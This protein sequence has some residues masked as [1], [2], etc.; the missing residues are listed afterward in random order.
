ML[1]C[2]RLSDYRILHVDGHRLWAGQGYRLFFSDDNGS[3]FT[4]RAVY[5]APF[6]LKQL[7]RVP[8][9]ERLLRGGF[10]SLLPLGDG[11][12]L[13][14]I[15]GRIIHCKS[16]SQRFV[17]VLSVPGRTLKLCATPGGVIYAGEYFL[18]PRRDEVRVFRSLDRGLNW[19]VVHTFPPGAIRHVH[20][21]VYDAYRGWV[22]LLT[23][24]LD[25]EAKVLRT[26]DGFRSLDALVEGG[27][28]S[29]AVNT[30]PV[31]EGYY[32]PTDTQFEQNYVQF[33][34]LDGELT[35][36][37]PLAGSCL[38]ACSVGGWSFFGT[39]VEPSSVNLDPSVLLYGTR[40]GREWHV[41]SRW[42]VDRWSGLTRYSAAL[43]QMARI[44][45]P[46]GDNQTGFLFAT[47]VATRGS[48]GTLHRWRVV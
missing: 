8:A 36:L 47:P 44:L 26:A 28:R 5:S 17:E 18:N 14:G 7:T 41:I 43:F 39:A 3:S 1:S 34:S 27:Q 22:L 29:R 11:S 48:H 30:I 46:S 19:E 42:R 20:N 31:S 2:E 32:L 25:H 33:L 21:V 45:L 24:D 9:A 6:P 16:D 13:G 23:G 4:F 15:K 38:T 35:H 10:L 37:C 40:D 12:L